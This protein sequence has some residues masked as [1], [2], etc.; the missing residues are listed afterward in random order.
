MLRPSLV[1]S[2]I[3]R[4]GYWG[5]AATRCALPDTH[6]SGN[7]YF[8]VASGMVAVE[9]FDECQLVLVNFKIDGTTAAET[10]NGGSATDTAALWVGSTFVKPFTFAGALSG[11]MASAGYIVSD[12]IKLT[13][14]VRK[15]E[16]VVIRRFRNNNSGIH[17]NGT[18]TS[19]VDAAL[20]DDFY[21]NATVITDVT[22][23]G[24]LASGGG[25]H[26]TNAA[27]PPTALLCYRKGVSVA[28]I[29]D[30]IGWGYQDTVANDYRR[31]V[32][33]RGLT[34]LT[35]PFLN[36]SS[37]GSQATQ[38]RNT[39]AHAPVRLAL[40]RMGIFSN[41]ISQIG[42]NDLHVASRTAAQ[43]QGDIEWIIQQ[44]PY[45]KWTLATITHKVSSTSD[46]YVTAAGQTTLD[47]AGSQLSTLNTTIRSRG[48]AGQNNGYWDVAAP[49][50][51]DS[52]AH[53]GKWIVNG[54]ANYATA[55]GVHP[56]STAYPLASANVAPADLHWP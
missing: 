50:E 44:A 41:A 9:D 24:T 36:L 52:G 2:H 11:T 31:G 18:S 6:V 48:V 51:N 23:G 46:S 42:T 32:I 39:A 28:V 27:A 21:V 19:F 34:A 45:A 26:I 54:V 55:D 3:G 14:K 20:G 10:G 15:G 38:W 1:S 29:G 30:S 17:Y 35:M 33:C 16:N 12:R 7:H 4:Q 53:D 25:S 40:L 37:G 43:T 8:N 22:Q 49:L 56:T 47:G 13:R 5:L